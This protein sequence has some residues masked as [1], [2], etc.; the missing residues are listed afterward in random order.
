MEGGN[1]NNC[2]YEP[3]SMLVG[4]HFQRDRQKINLGLNESSLQIP[5]HIKG[6]VIDAL[7]RLHKYPLGLEST[8]IEDLAKFYCVDPTQVTITHGV[9][10]ALDRLIEFL[11][12]QCGKILIDEAYIDYSSERTRLD[13]LDEKTFVF[14]SLSKVFALAGQRLGFLFGDEANIAPIKNRQWFCNTN[15][16]SLE[17]IRAILRDP[18][19]GTHADIVKQNREKLRQAALGLGFDV[20]ETDGRKRHPHRGIAS[21]CDAN[22]RKRQQTVVAVWHIADMALRKREPRMALAISLGCPDRSIPERDLTAFPTSA[23]GDRCRRR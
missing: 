21:L 9:D 19:M 13:W 8:V 7:N 23:R 20:R 4:P 2:G 16:F 14:R 18:F 10:E 11:H 17:L 6:A 22:G 1:E 3:Y 15:V 12:R 5:P